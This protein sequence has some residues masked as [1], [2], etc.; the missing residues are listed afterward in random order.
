MRHHRCGVPG[1]RAPAHEAPADSG[2]GSYGN[3]AWE[4][5]R[6][7]GYKLRPGSFEWWFTNRSTDRITIAQMPNVPLVVF[8]VAIVASWVLHSHTQISRILG[9]VATGALVIWALDELIRGV[10]PW[11]RVLG[12]VVLGGTAVS[13]LHR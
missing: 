4:I 3:G 9:D 8:G 6:P 2:T 13:L 1:R 7:D 11:R 10:N 12:G 5:N